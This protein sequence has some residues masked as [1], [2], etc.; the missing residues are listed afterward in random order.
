LQV[1]LSLVIEGTA[2]LSTDLQAEL[3]SQPMNLLTELSQYV[4]TTRYYSRYAIGGK[5]S[6]DVN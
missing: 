6:F 1:F 2:G 3:V 4:L 5:L